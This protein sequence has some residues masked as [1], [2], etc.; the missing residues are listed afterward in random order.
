[1]SDRQPII[2]WRFADG[3]PGHEKQ[4]AGLVQALHNIHPCEVSSFQA[5]PLPRCLTDLLLKRSPVPAS[6]DT[7]DLV[8]GAGHATH[9]SLLA[10]TRAV[11]G[12]SIVIMKPSLPISWFDV[13][14]IP[15]HDVVAKN[16]HVILTEGAIN[17]IT[18]A[19]RRLAGTGLILLGGASRHFAWNEDKVMQQLKEITGNSQTTWQITTSRRTP[20][21]ISSKLPSLLSDNISCLPYNSCPDGWLDRELAQCETV[22]VTA[23]SVSMIH[24]SVTAGCR[25]GIIELGEARNRKIARSLNKLMETNMLTSFSKWKRTGEL[26]F[27]AKDLNEAG[28]CARLLYERYFTGENRARPE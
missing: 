15:E 1:M 7:P 28:R 4:S 18:P 2:I 26:P 16:A 9:L 11:G 10:T 23:D 21:S 25:T 5:S 20:E 8:I 6:A 17:T 22:W 13:C 3:N 12:R 24:E 27:P 14:L 19:S